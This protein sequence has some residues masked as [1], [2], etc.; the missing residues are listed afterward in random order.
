MEAH[1]AFGNIGDNVFLKY[2]YPSQDDFEIV[3]HD[4]K[5]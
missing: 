1:D 3:R 5:D 4:V 2:G